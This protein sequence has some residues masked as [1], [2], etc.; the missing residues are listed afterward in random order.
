MEPYNVNTDEYAC[1]TEAASI[2]SYIQSIVAARKHN[3]LDRYPGYKIN[4]RCVFV[5]EEERELYSSIRDRNVPFFDIICETLLHKDD[6][7]YLE[8]NEFAYQLNCFQK[9]LFHRVIW[10]DAVG[11]NRDSFM[12]FIWKELKANQPLGEF[13]Q[14]E[15][16][17]RSLFVEAPNLLTYLKQFTFN[18]DYQFVTLQDVRELF[19][20]LVDSGVFLGKYGDLY[21][22]YSN[23]DI[24]HADTNTK[25]AYHQGEFKKLDYLYLQSKYKVEIEPKLKSL[26]TKFNFIPLSDPDGK[27][28][29]T[30]STVKLSD[31]VHFIPQF[32]VFYGAV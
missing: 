11:T 17:A 26:K 31:G 12:D 9:N 10:S 7:G 27:F 28:D 6:K 5:F 29:G 23:T 3:L 18:E 25:R 30:W 4:P 20:A 2:V 15:S 13:D 19:D 8:I 16:I 14:L 22:V 32:L 21:H 24:D 1:S